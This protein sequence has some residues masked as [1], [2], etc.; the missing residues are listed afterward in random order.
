[1][2]TILHLE[3]STSV[4]SAA[5]SHEG[6]ILL[7]RENFDGQSHST[8]VGV[9][10]EEMM[11]YARQNGLN[12]DAVSVSS[13]PGSY[14]GLR[15]GVS[16]A[17][18]LSYGLGVPLIAIPTHTLMAHQMRDRVEDGALLCP[19]IDA[20]RM[21]VYAAFFDAQM[22]VVRPVSADIVDDG[23][24]LHLLEKHKI[25]FFGNGAEKCRQVITHPNAVFVAGV[26]P[27]ASAMTKLAE[28]AFRERQFADTAYFEPFY[29][30]EFVATV[31]K[32]PLLQ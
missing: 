29:L 7:N 19:M 11:S 31:A 25:Y 30:K 4:C 14:T 24:Y 18:G 6:K 26:H 20:R 28:K 8:L 16:E 21:E 15:I 9:F 10:A 1:M 17:K 23:S 12:P 13:G 22:N 3:T 5:L 32:N 2:C 27:L